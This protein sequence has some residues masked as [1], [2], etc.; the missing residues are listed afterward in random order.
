MPSYF[1][2]FGDDRM[3]LS[4]GNDRIYGLAGND[5]LD[6]GPG[7]DSL[8]GGDGNDVLFGSILQSRQR[9]S[10]PKYLDGGA[11][12]D[13]VVYDESLVRGIR[14]D[15]NTGI[16]SFEHN[17]ELG[18]DRLVNIEAIQA[19]DGW[20]RIVG[21]R[22]ANLFIGAGGR[23]TL[24]GN[25]GADSLSGGAGWDRLI[26]GMG[27]DVLDG[28]VGR[29]VVFGGAGDDILF[30]GQG[31]DRLYGG[32]GTD[33]LIVEATDDVIVSLFG[34]GYL[35]A[36]GRSLLRSIEN[37]GTSEGNDTISGNAADNVINA[38][39]GNNVVSGLVGDDTIIGGD[40]NDVLLGGWGDD[41]LV[42]GSASDDPGSAD[43]LI[44]GAGNDTLSAYGGNVRLR[45]GADADT[46]SFIDSYPAGSYPRVVI[47]D[48][49]EGEIID[50][51]FNFGTPRFVGQVSQVDLQGMG[52]YEVAF[53]RSGE[54]T[55]VLVR[56]D[57][58]D[59][60][61]DF[62]RINLNNFDGALSAGNFDLL[63]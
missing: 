55:V 18:V 48:F 31:A 59:V 32:A 12:Y 24:I 20:D 63:I 25:N 34:N 35:R 45:G 27:A 41:L 22:A 38:G 47:T 44:G 5:T 30:A 52:L 9:F 50:F 16:V 36:N 21:D 42:G 14:A 39:D 56:L 53:M 43:I 3:P 17:S 54:S 26:G 37:V 46:F 58:A 61:Q 62:L 4:F 51:D 11:G 60:G 7:A 29:D 10:G 33:T 19:S 6:G 23:D 57:D 40:G 2:T 49:S 15:L 28:G 8:F 13:R 1:G